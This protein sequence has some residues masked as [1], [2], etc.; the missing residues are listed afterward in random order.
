MAA[1]KIDPAQA[2]AVTQAAKSSFMVSFHVATA[3]SAG[4]VLIAL[5]ILLWRLPAKAEAVAWAAHT[6]TGPAEE[7]TLD[8]LESDAATQITDVDDR[9]LAHGDVDVEVDGV[10][11]THAHDGGKQP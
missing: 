7:P 4:L 6:G 10:I 3:L 2:L 9:A 8:K 1:G 11:E 5:L